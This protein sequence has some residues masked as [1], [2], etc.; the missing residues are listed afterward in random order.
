MRSDDTLKLAQLTWRSDFE[1][2]AHAHEICWETDFAM[3]GLAVAWFERSFRRRDK[4]RPATTLESGS[5]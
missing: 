2:Y 3:S 5:L 4:D 1:R